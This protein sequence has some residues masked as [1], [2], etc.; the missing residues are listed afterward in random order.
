MHT[1]VHTRTH[2][3]VHTHMCTRTHGTHAHTHT[4][5]HT[6]NALPVSSLRLSCSCVYQLEHHNTMI[7]TITLLYTSVVFKSLDPI[8]PN[9]CLISI[10]AHKIQGLIIRPV[11]DGETPLVLIRLTRRFKPLSIGTSPGLLHHR[12]KN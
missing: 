3:H 2:T 1:H 7:I 8:D 10:L 6:L 11:D 9:S 4:H 5:T 12:K